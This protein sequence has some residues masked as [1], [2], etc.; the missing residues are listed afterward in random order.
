MPHVRKQIRDAFLTALSGAASLSD[1]TFF[2]NKFYNI[3]KSNS[4]LIKISPLNE[5]STVSSLGLAPVSRAMRTNELLVEVV[6]QDSEEVD[7]YD[8]LDSYGAKVEVALFA[9]APILALC[10]SME[11][12][13]ASFDVMVGGSKPVGTLSMTFSTEIHTTEANPEV[14]I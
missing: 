13:S 6:V 7:L 11:Y 1:V 8:T 14:V 3:E 12:K 10:R 9:D 4:P 2:D 5:T